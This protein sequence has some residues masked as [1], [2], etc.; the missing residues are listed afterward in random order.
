MRL[1]YGD[2]ISL[3]PSVICDQ[4]SFH[5]SAAKSTGLC[6]GG[7]AFVICFYFNFTIGNMTAFGMNFNM[8]HEYNDPACK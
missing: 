6:R 2:L 4:S 7:K 3:L 8:I 1:S 5:S